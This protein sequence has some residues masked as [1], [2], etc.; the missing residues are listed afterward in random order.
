MHVCI[1]ISNV[2]RNESKILLPRNAQSTLLPGKPFINT[3]VPK[4]TPCAHTHV[5]ECV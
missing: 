1:Y 2:S 4:V 3:G 5:A